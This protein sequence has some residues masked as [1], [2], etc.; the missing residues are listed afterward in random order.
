MITLFLATLLSSPVQAADLFSCNAYCTTFIRGSIDG[1]PVEKFIGARRAFGFSKS[2]LSDAFQQ[3]SASCRNRTPQDLSV[4]LDIAVYTV[5]YRGH[6][7]IH[8]STVS[9]TIGNACRSH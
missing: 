1:L 6:E 5:N 9:A 4:S 7:I 8:T 3:M 2:S